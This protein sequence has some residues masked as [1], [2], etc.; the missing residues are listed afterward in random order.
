M[1]APSPATVRREW[2]K[3]NAK[4]KIMGLKPLKI[5]DFYY[6]WYG[7]DNPSRKRKNPTKTQKRAKA[8]TAA[9]KRGIASAVRSL[10]QKT[11]PSA[12]I[13]GARVV[14]LKGGALKITPVKSN[15]RAAFDTEAEAERF[16]RYIEKH[17]RAKVVKRGGKSVV[18]WTKSGHLRR[19]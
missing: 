2:K 17:A 16:A 8:R 4:R 7:L 1:S 13:S 19:K 14:K 15:P 12:A 6:Q 18:V 10:L 11:N 9:K 5:H 3:E